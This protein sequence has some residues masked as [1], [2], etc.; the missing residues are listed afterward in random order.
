M[1]T[2]EALDYDAF[3]RDPKPVLGYSDLTAPLNALAQR[4]R[5]VT[6]HGP[7]MNAPLSAAARDRIARALGEHDFGDARGGEVITGGVARGRLCGGNLSLIAHL[8][9]TPYALDARDA[10]VFLE[11]LDEAPYRIDRMLTQL[12][13]AGWFAAAR[14]VAVGDIEHV[15]VVRERLQDLGIPVLAGLPFGHIGEQCVMPI[16][17]EAELDATNARLRISEG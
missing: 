4:S 13:L 10:V 7:V 17:A 16:G 9:G 12:R 11:D 1:R 3:A 5:V 8:C 6:F 15:D 14:G 2:L